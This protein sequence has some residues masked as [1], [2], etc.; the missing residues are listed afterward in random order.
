MSTL[1]HRLESLAR[2]RDKTATSRLVR[3]LV[4]EFAKDRNAGPSPLER[5][6]F[7]RI[8]LLVLD[9]LD[10]ATRFELVVRLAKTSHITS[11]LA[12][13]LTLEEFE[14]SEPVLQHSPVVT[15]AALL[16]AARFASD[17]HRNAIARRTA[18]SA[19]VCDALIARSCQ[20]TI[21]LLL[22]NPFAR[23]S[24]GAVIALLIHA[25]S[26]RHVLSG[27]AARALLDAPYRAALKKLLEVGCPLFPARLGH[28]LEQGSLEQL[29]EQC[30]GTGPEDTIDH[31]G[32]RLSRHEASIEVA[33]GDLL[34]DSLLQTLIRQGRREAASWLMGRQ[35]ALPAATVERTLSSNA[36]G[37]VIKL[38]RD[39]GVSARTYR[40]FLEASWAGHHRSARSIV[41]LVHRYRS[42]LPKR[43]IVYL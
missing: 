35:L 25:G 6:L 31:E 42:E 16:N 5:E 34:F 22:A 9:D 29:A 24:N 19:K 10:K 40:A 7:S 20:E 37:T 30:A 4:T 36:D 39:S 26:N 15:D 3:E 17:A 14:Q 8:V 32:V 41:S 28:A 12:D 1:R 33:N 13:R 38:M 43:Q 21:L 11:E 18:L 2:L 23:F 27:V